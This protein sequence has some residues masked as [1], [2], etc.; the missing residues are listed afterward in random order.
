M[1][2]LQQRFLLLGLAL[3]GLAAGAASKPEPTVCWNPLVFHVQQARKVLKTVNADYS[4]E[5]MEDGKVVKIQNVKGTA[6][7]AEYFTMVRRNIRGSSTRILRD[8]IGDVEVLKVIWSDSDGRFSISLFDSLGAFAYLSCSGTESSSC[9][10]NDPVVDQFNKAFQANGVALTTEINLEKRTISVS[11][12]SFRPEDK[13]PV[14]PKFP[15]TF[16]GLDGIKYKVVVK[17]GAAQG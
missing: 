2:V 14:I 12:I 11:Y 16:I 15:A 3:S 1:G 17:S 8:K 4:G 9:E 7:R 10:F 13:A 5:L 6:L